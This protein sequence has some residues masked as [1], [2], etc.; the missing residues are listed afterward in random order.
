MVFGSPLFTINTSL[1][2]YIMLKKVFFFSLL[3]TL[4]FLNAKII[5][6]PAN[7]IQ[8]LETI[9]SNFHQDLDH[10]ENSVYQFQK[11]ITNNYDLKK[12]QK[13]H[14][15]LRIAFKKV[16]YLVEQID[17]AGIKQRINGAPLPKTEP[18][19][20][21]LTIIQPK[22]L[23]TLDELLFSENPKTALIEIRK[24][25]DLL[26]KDIELMTRYQKGISLTHQ[27]VFHA[28]RNEV[29]RMMTLG[30]S[31]FD[32]PGSLNALNEATTV[33]KTLSKSLTVYSTMLHPEER[34]VCTEIDEAIYKGL[35]QIQETDS[36]E[37]F[38][39]L[40][41]LKHTVNPLYSNIY[42]LQLSLGIETP[43]EVHALGMAVNYEI[44][45]LFDEHFLDAYFYSNLIKDEST[46]A[47]IALGQKLFYDPILSKNT[48]LSC[49]SCHDPNLY[50][51]DGKEK[52][53]GSVEHST[54]QRNAPTLVN[55]VF[56][57]NYFYDLREDIFEKQI[58][59]V[60][61]SHEEFNTDFIE[62]IEKLGRNQEYDNAFTALYGDYGISP[63]SITN[64]ISHYVQSIVSFDS[65]FDQYV[66][67]ESKDLS[68]SAKRGFNLFM[69]KATCGTCHFLPTFSGLVP[70]LFQESESEVLG[71]PKNKNNNLLDDDLGRVASGKPLDEAP[72]YVHS[73][74]TT[75]IRNIEKTAPYM[76]NGVY[77][78]L[79]E[80]L[81]FY[82]K[83]GGQGLG[84]DVP[85][86][87]LSG[88]PLD[89]TDDET[90]DI[91][92]FMKSL[93]DQTVKEKFAIEY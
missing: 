1:N 15:D 21:D 33:L 67:D 65:P 58:K 5:Q 66:R 56:A 19:V 85:Y 32:T 13:A 9:K 36:F 41:F 22:G 64:T 83:G 49:G 90:K 84:L 77:Q 82:N 7:P 12:A 51:T 54:L 73:F 29:I 38:D 61:H 92:A 93:T 18:K 42:N 59:H 14:L 44:E 25:S 80:V 69:G 55:A 35:Q 52:S 46:N 8:A 75:T 10:L 72:F 4:I 89:L 37:S 91:I 48:N 79:E 27:L 81:D 74:K 34:S 57:Q 30:V 71:V 70:P 76:H 68:E 31:G 86:Q 40:S 87:T 47:K 60:I 88:D 62:I 6:S 45:N 43:E 11:I 16:E 20:A 53:L 3:T 78:T 63:H 2:L 17:P 24:L 26:V 28:C 23:Q 50:F 39:R